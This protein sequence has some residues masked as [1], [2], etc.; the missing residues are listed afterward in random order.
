MANQFPVKEWLLVRI[1][2]EER[3]YSV[4]VTASRQLEVSGSI[5]DRFIFYGV[6]ITRWII[7]PKF[8]VWFLIKYYS[9]MV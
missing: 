3:I 1:Q 2:V 4:M 9:P 6:M 8:Q 5:P 7:S